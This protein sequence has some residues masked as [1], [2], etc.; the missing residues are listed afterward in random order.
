MVIYKLNFAAFDE[1]G[2]GIPFPLTPFPFRPAETVWNVAKH[3][4]CFAQNGFA[5]L[6]EYP[7]LRNFA[8]FRTL[9]S[10]SPS[11]RRLRGAQAFRPSNPTAR[12]TIQKPLFASKIIQ[13]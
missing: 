3:L 6:S 7:T 12:Q 4:R 13:I 1:S 11:A 9:D 10:A 5:L 2:A 8:I